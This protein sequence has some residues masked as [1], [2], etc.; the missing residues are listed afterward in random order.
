MQNWLTNRPISKDKIINLLATAK[1]QQL[2]PNEVFTMLTGLVNIADIKVKNIMT[3]RNSIVYFTTADTLETM[4]PILQQHTY[5]KYPYFNQQADE[6][7]GMLYTKD[8]QTAALQQQFDLKEITR[9]I[10]YVPENQT[11][12]SLL[13]ELT[14]NGDKMVVVVDEFGSVVGIATITD[15]LKRLWSKK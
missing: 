5:G 7:L 9:K 2:L 4:L 1:Q 3:G 10:T 15:I 13:K 12:G 6:V 14:T 11:V 8:I